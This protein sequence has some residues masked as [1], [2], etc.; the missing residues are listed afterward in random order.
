MLIGIFTVSGTLHFLRPG[1]FVAIVPKRLPAKKEL[2]LVSG[3]VEL[4]CAG[5]LAVPR[6]RPAGGVLSAGLLA[7]VFPA[8]VSMALRSKRKPAWYRVA[9]WARLP[10]Q[11]PLIAWALR[12]GRGA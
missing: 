4:V 7:G 8:N 12:A 9:V 1:P 5:L 2:V 6:T 3:G 11:I 10:L